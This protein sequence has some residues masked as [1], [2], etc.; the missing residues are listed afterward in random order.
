VLNTL[1]PTQAGYVDKVTAAVNASVSAGF[2]LP[3]DAA[4]T[5]AEAKASVYGSGRE[6]G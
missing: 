4:E 3:E 6:G 5:I 1:Y 2:V